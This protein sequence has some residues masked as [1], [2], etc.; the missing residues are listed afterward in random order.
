MTDTKLAVRLQPRA[1]RD[2]LVGLHN[3]VVVARVCAPP[4]D[5]EANH[6][7]CRLIARS[8][9]VAPARVSV[10]AGKQGRLKLLRVVGIDHASLIE[11]LG[12]VE[13]SS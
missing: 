4:V 3:G 5:G 8:A 10:I 1:H 2:E 9:G 13:Q 7:L 11:A 6:A 12:V